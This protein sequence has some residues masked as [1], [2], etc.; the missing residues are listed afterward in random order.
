MPKSDFIELPNGEAVPIL[1]EDRSVLAID[2]PRKWMLVP[3]NWKKSSRNLQAVL[4]SSIAAGDFWAR[5]RGITYLRY[6]H[7]LDAETTGVLLLAKSP[8]GVSSYGAL[9]EGRQVEKHYL[10]VVQGHPKE[11][12]W[13]CKLKLA[14]DSN[15]VGRVQ[16]EPSR[17]KDAETWFRVS[18]TGESTTLLEAHP[19]TGRTH[20]IR[21]HLAS[22]GHPV[23]GDDLYGPTPRRKHLPLALRSVFLAYSDPFTRRRVEIRAP[24]GR[25]LE[26]YGFGHS[27]SL[28][29]GKREA[30]KA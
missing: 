17:G 23:V 9:F 13:V 22:A 3:A 27:P 18:Q 14:R 21:V 20:Q 8:G 26:C 6:I 19:V 4:I 15:E 16:V 7:R 2:K 1:Y 30:L 28:E 5:S 12:E 25:F 10:A 11:K 29:P 24:A